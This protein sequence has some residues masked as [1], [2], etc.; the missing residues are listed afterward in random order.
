ML[1]GSKILTNQLSGGPYWLTH[2]HS[3]QL[4]Q[5][6][7]LPPYPMQTLWAQRT[8]WLN[9][10]L[11]IWHVPT[12]AWLWNFHIFFMWQGKTRFLRVFLTYLG[13]F[14][15]IFD[16]GHMTRRVSSGYTFITHWR[17]MSCWLRGATWPDACFFVQVTVLEAFP[18]RP[19]EILVHIKPRHLFQTRR[20]RPI[21]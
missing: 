14:W 8:T 15:P 2:F 4:S 10:W 20:A 17:Q 5:S 7:F 21:K 19:H 12:S 16:A 3:V 11:S 18:G 6:C 13:Q 1:N 9:L